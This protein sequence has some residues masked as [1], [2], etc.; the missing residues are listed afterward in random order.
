M[1]CIDPYQVDLKDSNTKFLVIDADFTTEDR[2]HELHLYYTTSHFK[3]QRQAVE[4]AEIILK[5]S[6]NET[7][8]Y[9][10]KEAGKYEL[11]MEAMPAKEG[12]AYHLEIKFDG[13]VYHS[14][15]V[16][17]PQ[18]VKADSTYLRFEAFEELLINGAINR[19][20]SVAVF[21]DSKIPQDGRDFWLK[22]DV[23]ILYSFPE[24][25]CGPLAPPPKICFVKKQ[26][27]LEQV[28]LFNGARSDVG[29]ISELKVFNEFLG[30]EDFEFRGRHYYLVS[31]KSITKEA[32][33]YW[34]KVNK[35][36]NQTGSIF[37]VPPAGIIG[38][39]F[40]VNDK[41]E[42]V[43][44]YFEVANSHILRAYTTEA[45]LYEH[46]PFTIDVCPNVFNPFSQFYRE[47]CNCPSIENSTLDRP[48]WF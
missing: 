10:N 19:I 43:L 4:N 8:V 27:I 40:N 26:P 36:S 17:M 29:R 11:P 47:C 45:I 14:Q 21:V 3:R 25:Y 5:S 44:G 1:T 33:D 37:D 42:T 31:Q 20:P 41:E 30:N 28:F 46:H 48:S 16:I 6:N 18:A 22:W 2:V 15:P 24:V 13:Q 34:S 35:L 7:A 38:N 39:Y 12:V 32:Y 9:E 23:E